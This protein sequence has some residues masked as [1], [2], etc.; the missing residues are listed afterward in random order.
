MRENKFE[1]KEVN[2]R[3]EKEWDGRI[4]EKKEKGRDRIRKE[5][6]K[7]TFFQ[8]LTSAES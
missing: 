1:K 5:S 7:D 4:S 3:V 2:F 8:Y 6:L